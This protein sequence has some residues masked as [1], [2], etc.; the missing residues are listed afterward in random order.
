MALHAGGMS[1]PPT[2]LIICSRDRPRMLL[3]TVESV[4]QGTTLPTE[5]I[6]IDQSTQRHAQLSDLVG[7]DRCR[8]RYVWSDAVGLSRARNLGLAAASHAIVAFTDD[9]MRV[10]PDWYA[11]LIGALI[12]AGPGTVTTGRVLAGA[13]EA[14]GTFVP[15]LVTSDLPRVSEGRIG[16]DVL[17]GCQFAMYRSV[18]D[19]VGQFDERLGVGARFPAAEDNDFGFRLLEAGY[20]TAYIPGAVIYHRAW[21]TGGEYLPKRWAYGRGQGGF[22]AKFASLR[23][24]YVLRRACWDVGLHLVRFPWRSLH[25]P[26][27]ALGDLAYA[28]GIVAGAAEWTVTYRL[29]AGW[30]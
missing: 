18:F 23:D 24:P 21:R 2:S 7:D 17:A 3:E 6:V 30:R 14:P 26:R 8:L 25:R 11:A 9:D 12:Q 4:L 10:A 19:A 20:S 15:A 13:P 29:A 5:L 27:L 28:L 22:Y 16:T 1:L